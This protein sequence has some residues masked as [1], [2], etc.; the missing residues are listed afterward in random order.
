MKKPKRTL[1]EIFIP[2]SVYDSQVIVLIGHTKEEVLKWI[3]KNVEND[4]KESAK[5]LINVESCTRGR[6][7]CLSGGG[8]IIWI[9]KHNNPVLV[10]ELFHATAHL[11]RIKGIPLTQE[12]EEAYAYLL[13]YL[14]ESCNI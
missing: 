5:G 1:R 13:G 14:T 3:D 12:S 11:L 4:V 7:A 6:T 10:H 8:S 9:V 2:V